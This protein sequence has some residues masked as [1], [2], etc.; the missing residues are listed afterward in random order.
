[1]LHSILH[2]DLEINTSCKQSCIMLCHDIEDDKL[3]ERF[4]KSG[5][6]GTEVTN[7]A[8]FSADVHWGG[9]YD[10]PKENFLR[11]LW[12]KEFTIKSR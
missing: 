8:I 11:R 10:Q 9:M 6:K 2:G 7:E 12:V 5:K 4:P 3:S 1:M